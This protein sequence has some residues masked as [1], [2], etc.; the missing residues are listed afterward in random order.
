[1]ST[2]LTEQEREALRAARPN[3]HWTE[4]AVEVIVAARVAAERDRLLGKVEALM[5]ESCHHCGRPPDDDGDHTC[6]CPLTDSECFEHTAD[7][8]V[9]LNALRALVA[10]ERTT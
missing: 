8:V 2:P 6:P 4:Q 1:M 3:M 9:G 7:P 10:E 5:S